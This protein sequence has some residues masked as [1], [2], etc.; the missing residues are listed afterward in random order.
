MKVLIVVDMQNDFIDGTLAADGGVAIVSN[1]VNRIKNSEHELILFTRD[2]HGDD[3]LQ[4]P[5][6]KKLPVVHCIQGSHGWQIQPD[7]FSAWQTHPATLVL[8]ELP[9]P[10]FDKPVFGSIQLVDFLKA[11]EQDIEAIEMLG[12]CTDICVVSNAIMVKNSLPNVPLSVNANCCAG[13]SKESHDKALAVMQMCQ[14][15]VF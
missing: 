1:V 3:Y 5:E 15:D 12:I 4:T 8:P 10:I 6:G 7:I 2:T 11:H 14:I 9:S 13:V